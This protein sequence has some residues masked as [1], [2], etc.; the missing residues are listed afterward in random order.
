MQ[1]DTVANIRSFADKHELYGWDDASRQLGVVG[2]E[3]GELCEAI[4]TQDERAVEEEAADVIYTVLLLSDIS[5]VSIAHVID[6]LGETAR[7]NLE[8]NVNTEGNKVTKE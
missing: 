8:K 2:E 5:R 7:E 6:K 3:F 1:E 4:T